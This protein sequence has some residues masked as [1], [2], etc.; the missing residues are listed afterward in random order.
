MLQTSV[1]TLKQLVTSREQAQPAR[2][3]V[4]SENTL[5]PPAVV[6]SNRLRMLSFNIQVGINTQHYRHYV[7]RSW[8]HVLPSQRRNENLDQ[9]AYLLR[10][11]DLVALQEVDGG[12]IRSGYINQTEYLARKGHFPYWYHQLN[13]DLGRFAQHSNGFLCRANP[14][15]VEDHKLPG[16]LPGRGAIVVRLG[17]EEEHIIIVMMHLSLSQRSRNR[18]L[19]YICD[20]IAEHKHIVLMGDMNTHAEQLLEKTPL[21][22]GHLRPVHNGEF[23]FPSWRP[24]RSIDHILVSDKIKI[25][26]VNVLNKRLSDHLP[27]AV[28]IELPF[29][30]TFPQK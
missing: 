28:E 5:R 2:A 22:Y 1:R 15:Q 4:M 25:N 16:R 7:T 23:T 14:Q 18:Q 27:V 21:R 17:N 6:L 3:N 11:F 19:S 13:R 8:Q 29:E 26:E 24:S 9:I 30:L 20:L 12:S 10:E